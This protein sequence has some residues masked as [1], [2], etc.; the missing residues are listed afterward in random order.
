MDVNIGQAREVDREIGSGVLRG[1][2]I[3]VE[4]LD[5]VES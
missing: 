5:S 3:E 2:A 4:S 1:R